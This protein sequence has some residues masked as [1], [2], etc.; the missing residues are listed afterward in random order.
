MS[1]EER[2]IQLAY[3]KECQM[4]ERVEERVLEMREDSD[5]H[6]LIYGVLGVDPEEGKKVDVYQN[7]GRFLYRYA[8]TFAEE[9]AM[10]CFEEKF[11]RE[12]AK[13]VYVPNPVKNTSPKRFE[14]DCLVNDE[15]AYEIKWR[16]ATTDGDHINKENRRVKAIKIKG[17]VP[18][19][20]TFF[21]PNRKQAIKIQRRLHKL[22]EEQG[23]Y[24]YSGKE[25]WEHLHEVTDI[26][27]LGILKN[28]F[29]E[30]EKRND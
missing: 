10:L 17:Y 12:N 3:D 14:V 13:T 9:A 28:I 26:D 27:L 18:M 23:G 7:K 4:S 1:I 2:I 20:L 29:T 24:Y 21:P 19:R 25:A 8:G 5:N 22:Y 11:G 15:F 6:Y 30:N 16:D